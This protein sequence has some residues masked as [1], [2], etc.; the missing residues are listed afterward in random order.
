V[1][2]V[3]LA[4]LLSPEDLGLFAAPFR[5]VVGLVMVA[6][7]TAWALLPSLARNKGDAKSAQVMNRVGPLAAAATAVVG[8]AFV[9][10]SRPLVCLTFGAV[11]RL[12]TAA[13]C[14]R[15]LALLPALHTVTYIMELELLAA[16]RQQWALVGAAPA[17][18]VKVAADLL[19][20][21]TLGP[22]TGAVSSLMADGIRL[23]LMMRVSRSSW[24]GRAMIPIAAL[25][26]L[27]AGS[28]IGGI[29]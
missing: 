26:L 29:P 21:G 3:L 14:L 7:P 8:A 18:A 11:P 10:G 9:L 24:M 5:L 27:V 19:L 25:G 12:D 28:L 13:T 17:L 1:D 16:G 23:V 15:L 4:R 20:V 22:L 6:V 2:N